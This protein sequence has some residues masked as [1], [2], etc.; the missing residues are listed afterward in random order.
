[1]TALRPPAAAS[2]DPRESLSTLDRSDQ[3]SDRA[4]FQQITDQ[5]RAA[6]DAG[7][8][9]PSGTLPPAATLTAYLGAARRTAH[10]EQRR[11]CWSGRTS[12][13]QERTTRT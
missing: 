3:D 1:M 9:R 10:Q 6:V 7:L 4:V 8:Y 13:Q 2:S 12:P 5:L 11:Q